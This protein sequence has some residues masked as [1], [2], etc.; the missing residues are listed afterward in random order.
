MFL[1]PHEDR[2]I[3]DVEK[4]RA[5]DV[6]FFK[7]IHKGMTEIVEKRK[8][9]PNN[10]RDLYNPEKIDEDLAYVREMKRLFELSKTYDEVD[11]NQKC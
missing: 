10:F 8:I 3:R 4:A 1:N 9:D 2:M 6:E 11:R 5:L 7:R